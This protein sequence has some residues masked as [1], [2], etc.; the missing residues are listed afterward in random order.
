MRNLCINPLRF[1]LSLSGLVALWVATAAPLSV[2]GNNTLVFPQFVNN[3]G[4][5]TTITLDNIN[6]SATVHGILTV[7]NQDGTIRGT[8][9]SGQPNPFSITIPPGG[10][11]TYSTPPGGGTAVS[12]MATFVSDFP[13][14]GVVQFQFAGGQIGVLDVPKRKLATLALNTANGNDTGL[15]IADSGT[16]SINVELRYAD[17]SGN[18]LDTIDPPELNPLPANG[19]VAKFIENF[20]FHV[21][22]SNKSSGSIQI[23]STGKGNFHAFGLLF[24]G[25]TNLYASTATVP[26]VSGKLDAGQFVGSYTGNW[27]NGAQQ[28]PAIVIITLVEST[29]T[30]FLGVLLDPLV[31]NLPP[32]A[33]STFVQLEGTQTSNG[34][35][36]TGTNS[37]AGPITM[38][39]NTDGSFTV[40][41]NSPPN[42][43]IFTSFTMTGTIYSDNISGN[44]STQ[45]SGSSNNGTISLQHT[46]TPLASW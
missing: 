19:Q 40:S 2:N 10:T 45:F 20:P 21:S 29:K 8:A 41:A 38:T 16:D 46:N 36:L 6:H 31:F 43:S 13:A 24:N 11:V 7:Y 12:G 4:Y 27:S 42:P 1:L 33:G 30:I 26:G 22:L 25:N 28:G 44:F 15:A 35:T 5:V 32:S 39:I 3:G 14:G 18:V 17:A 37:T 34:V 23:L 9:I